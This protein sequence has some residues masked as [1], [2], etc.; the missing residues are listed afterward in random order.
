M[1]YE[2]GLVV[3]ATKLLGTQGIVSAR[4]AGRDGDD[5]ILEAVVHIKVRDLPAAVARSTTGVR[6]ARE[7]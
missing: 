2:D 6:T 1:E 7:T 4:H 3:L 5:D